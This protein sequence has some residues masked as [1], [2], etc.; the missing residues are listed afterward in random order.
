MVFPPSQLHRVLARLSELP[1]GFARMNRIALRVVVAVVLGGGA[2]L[3]SAAAEETHSI[4]GELWD[5]RV[6]F[7]RRQDIAYVPGATDVMVHRARG[8]GFNFLHD[9]AIVAHKG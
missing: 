5:E 6:P 8:D 4:R 2:L 3:V 9:S 1:G 7:P